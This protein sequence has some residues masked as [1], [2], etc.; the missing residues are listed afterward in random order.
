MFYPPPR[1]FLSCAGRRLAAAIFLFFVLLWQTPA[2]ALTLG[3]GA[4]DTV[5]V[6]TFADINAY[7]TNDGKNAGAWVQ[8]G[9]RTLPNWMIGNFFGDAAVTSDKLIKT[10]A[11]A[12]AYLA[13]TTR[14]TRLFAVIGSNLYSVTALEALNNN[15]ALTDS[16]LPGAIT[17]AAASTAL[18]DS[19]VAT[20]YDATAVGANA[21]SR[22]LGTAVGS[23]ANAVGGAT[24]LGY[25]AHARGDASVAVGEG[26]RV[27]DGRSVAVGHWA[28][29]TGGDST[30]VGTNT[31][32][33][34]ADA[35]VLGVHASAIGDGNTALGRRA[36]A[37]D[38]GS[39]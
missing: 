2:G 38:W 25:N 37:A 36:S 19:A 34:G 33:F 26:S 15:A 5:A 9:T 7:N 29:T 3:S 14:S 1:E 17:L 24:A 6:P 22:D 30:L 4:D 8:I 13:D 39:E 11:N 21:N 20:A 27:F 28:R 32:G 16:N 23:K 35:A 12:A 18:G 10:Y 31:S